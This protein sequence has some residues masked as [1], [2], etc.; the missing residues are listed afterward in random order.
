MEWCSVDDTKQQ[1]EMCAD[2]NIVSAA[3]AEAVSEN[4]GAIK[5]VGKTAKMAVADG[6]QQMRE[7]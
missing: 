7:G 5:T 2:S 6:R 1:P 4:G 3:E